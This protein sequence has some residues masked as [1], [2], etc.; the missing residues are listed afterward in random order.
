MTIGLFFSALEVWV[1]SH[2]QIISFVF[3]ILASIGVVVGIGYK[4]YIVSMHNEKARSD[5]R[6]R[7]E[8]QVRE[9]AHDF[10]LFNQRQEFQSEFM[11]IQEVRYKDGEQVIRC[12]AK[13]V[14]HIRASEGQ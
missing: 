5:K 4:V 3:G 12:M 14:A 1:I 10:A 7:Y 2:Y 9:I 6:D 8:D 11:A 13:D